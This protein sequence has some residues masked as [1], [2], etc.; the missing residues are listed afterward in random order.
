MLCA[1]FFA[2]AAQ[3]QESAPRI[4]PAGTVT[5]PAARF[6]FSVFASK[7]ALTR[8][9]QIF[10][11]GKASPPLGQD[12]QASRAFYDKINSDRAERMKKLYPVEI[13]AQKFGVVGADVVTPKGGVDKR[14]AQRVLINLHG[15]AFLWGAGSGGLVEA[16]PIASVGKIKVVTIDYRQGPEHVFPAAS[17]DVE[18][19]YRELLKTYKP[20]NIG[21]YGCSAGGA[22]TAEA[23]AW[24]QT[25]NL[26]APG[27]IGIFCA[28]VVDLNGD[29]AYTGH[30]LMGEKVPEQAFPL[31]A[32]PYFK[33]ADPASPLVLPG[34]SGAVLAK[35]PP[36]LLISGSR[37]FSMSATLRSNELLTEAGAATELHVWEGMWH[38]FFSDPELPESKAMY[39]VVARFFDRELGRVRAAAN[40]EH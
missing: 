35:F 10:E 25:K 21:I 8:F 9:G 19:V 4:D 2:I 13:A 16:I 15:G 37:D 29:S 27:A 24:L 32:L 7:E 11:E 34:L 5:A 26:P 31:T 40:K 39:A 30:L 3:A 36:T 38:S 20:Q 18:K 14:N 22:L 1:G 28:G 6:P 33:G 12:I 17:E 23:A